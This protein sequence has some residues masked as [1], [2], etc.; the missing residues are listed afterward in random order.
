MVAKKPW[1]FSTLVKWGAVA[2]VAAAVIVWPAAWL[3]ERQAVT[4]QYIVPLDEATVAANRFLYAEE[5]SGEDADIVANYGTASGEPERIVFADASRIVRPE[6]NP[7]LALYPKGAGENPI[8]V[9]TVYF[10]AKVASFGGAIG[11]GALVLLLIL[12]RRRQRAAAAPGTA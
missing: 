7:S 6:E 3:I 9:Q 5:P 4:V 1:S 12:L 8:Q 2:A 11:A 10:F